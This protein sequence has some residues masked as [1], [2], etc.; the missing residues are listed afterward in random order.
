MSPESG[1]DFSVLVDLDNVPDDKGK[2]ET[3]LATEAPAD[4][5]LVQRLEMSLSGSSPC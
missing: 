4:E 3:R 5:L 2:S 1:Y